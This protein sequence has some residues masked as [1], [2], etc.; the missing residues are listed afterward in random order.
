LNCEVCSQP[1]MNVHNKAEYTV[2][3]FN[4]HARKV[5]I[6]IYCLPE[7]EKLRNVQ[8]VRDVERMTY[9]WKYRRYVEKCPL[10]DQAECLINCRLKVMV[11]VESR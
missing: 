10:K 4:P 1:G 9:C 5:R 2:F 7:F 3:F 11:K 8:V 6:C